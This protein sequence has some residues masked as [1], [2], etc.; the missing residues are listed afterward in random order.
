MSSTAR[1]AAAPMR[2]GMYESFFL[3][4]VSPHE[5]V[6][7]WLRYTVHKAP[8]GPPH[9][10]LWC[11]VFDARRGRPYMYKRSDLQLSLPAGEWI[12]LEDNAIGPRGAR[13]HCGEANW[14]L[15]IRDA[16]SE[17]R[18]LSPAWLYRA[19]LPRTK[20]TS[21]A[22]VARFDGVLELV[23]RE[24]IELHGWP[25]MVGHN[26]GAEH[27]ERWIW[28]HGIAFAEQPDAWLDVALARVKVGRHLTPWAC[29]GALSLHTG[30][31]LRI[32]GLAARGT[33]VAE[34]PQRCT[35]RLVGAG[36]LT[37]DASVH[38]PADAA[39]GW[40]YV[41]PVREGATASTHDVA[42]CAVAALALTVTG[43]VGG[44]PVQLNSAH[45][46]AYE[47]GMREHDHGVPLASFA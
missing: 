14:T 17:L 46:G 22:P 35:L 2:A 34:N 32:G 41:D 29:S 31:R 21:P 9:G 4:A 28:L 40:R 8:G 5:P 3:R 43:P 15:H 6:G 18:H 11:T 1:F 30:Q 20:L 7:V 13:G 33:R 23:G 12:A 16:Q 36:G 25:G 26:W 42:N 27:A 19:P 37:V 24:P 44:T 45:G 47:L 38:V 39:A 10:A